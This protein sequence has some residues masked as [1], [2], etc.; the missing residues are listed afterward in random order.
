MQLVSHAL[1]FFPFLLFTISQIEIFFNYSFFLEY[2]K[3]VFSCFLCIVCVLQGQIF[4]VVYLTGD[5]GLTHDIYYAEET[6][7]KGAL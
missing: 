3:T 1:F 2:N 6:V 7:L 5:F 4:L